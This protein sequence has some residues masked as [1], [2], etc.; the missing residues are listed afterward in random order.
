MN[1][2]IVFLLFRGWTVAVGFVERPQGWVWELFSIRGEHT[3][4]VRA[5]SQ[6]D[7]LRAAVAMSIR[8]DA[9]GEEP[10]LQSDEAEEE[11]TLGF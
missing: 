2:L 1:E 8:I 7:A 4:F 3:M 11:E 6:M 9:E 10:S 5:N